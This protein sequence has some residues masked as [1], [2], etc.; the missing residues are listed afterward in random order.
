MLILTII[1]ICLASHGGTPCSGAHTIKGRS[2]VS[3][4]TLCVYTTLA[5]SVGAMAPTLLPL[6]GPTTLLL[7]T[8]HMETF[9]GQCGA[10]SGKAFWSSFFIVLSLTYLT[11][12]MLDFEIV[13]MIPLEKRRHAG[14]REDCVWEECY[15]ARGSIHIKWTDSCFERV[16]VDG[17]GVANGLLSRWFRYI[18]NWGTI[19]DGKICWSK[20]H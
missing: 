13:E 4:I 9:R 7:P 19:C 14:P 15:K 1:H 17:W 20:F 3:W 5:R 2:M 16:H 10:T 6:A 18:S 12:L 8:Q 11:L